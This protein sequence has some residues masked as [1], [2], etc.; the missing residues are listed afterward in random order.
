MPTRGYGEYAKGEARG[1]QYQELGH[2]TAKRLALSRGHM[3]RETEFFALRTTPDCQALRA[4]N[5]GLSATI[6]VTRA[7]SENEELVRRALFANSLA[8][9]GNSLGTNAGYRPILLKNS[10]FTGTEKFAGPQGLRF[11]SYVGGH[12]ISHCAPPRSF[13][14]TLRRF[15]GGIGDNDQR[16]QEIAS[17]AILSFST[18]S[19]RSGHPA[20]APRAVF[21]LKETIGPTFLPQL[22]TNAP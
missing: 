9:G 15:T 12:A 6:G 20:S 22:A 7:R 5:E 18:E 14:L 16:A 2:S 17:G 10:V 4:S 21:H 1:T 13:S 3:F 11:I 19:A 8:T